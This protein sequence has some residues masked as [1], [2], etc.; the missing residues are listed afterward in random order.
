MPIYQFVVRSGDHE[1]DPDVRWSHLPDKD[2]ARR[3]FVRS[4][5]VIASNG[6][7]HGLQ[8]SEARRISEAD[9]YRHNGR[10]GRH[11]RKGVRQF[12]QFCN[13]QGESNTAMNSDALLL[14]AAHLCTPLAGH[15]V[16]IE[17]DHRETS[18]NSTDLSFAPLVLR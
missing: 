2:A 16:L 7:R 13:R 4:S 1:D 10:D 15:G 18:R 5:L 6:A 8:V 12:E 11:E 9:G 14:T 3:P 17:E